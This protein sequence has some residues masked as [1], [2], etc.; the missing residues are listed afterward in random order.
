[1]KA[2]ISALTGVKMWVA[3]D[4]VAAHLEAGDKLA[5]P[6]VKKQAADAGEKMSGQSKTATEQPAAKKPA[7]KKP[8]AKK[9]AV[10]KPAT[11]KPAAKKS[12]QKKSEP[13]AAM[14]DPEEG[15][16]EW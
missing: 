8:A 14:P 2:M 10:K 13:K 7:T 5:S 1:M 6:H 11:K 3:D 4:Q 16:G 9:P 15:E 12:V